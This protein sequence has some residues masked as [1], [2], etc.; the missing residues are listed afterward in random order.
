MSDIF[1]ISV[2]ELGDH[3]FIGIFDCSEQDS[4]AS[5]KVLE[6]P[7]ILFVKFRGPGKSWKMGLVLESLGNFS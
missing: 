4:H 3:S 6:I 1:E 5:W 2:R 7:G